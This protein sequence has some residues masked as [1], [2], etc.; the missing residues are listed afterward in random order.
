MIE[1]NLLYPSF[2][3]SALL[4]VKCVWCVLH[5]ARKFSGLVRRSFARPWMWWISVVLFWQ[6]FTWHIGYCS[7]NCSLISRYSRFCL[8]RFSVIFFTGTTTLVVF[9][10]RSKRL[11]SKPHVAHSPVSLFSIGRQ[12]HWIHKFWPNWLICPVLIWCGSWFFWQTFK[13][14]NSNTVWVLVLWHPFQ[15]IFK[16]WILI[17]S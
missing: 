3:A 14:L 7:K 15:Y 2:K 17:D 6:S 8:A 5:I 13:L 4:V 10:L 12:S 1:R 16:T 11:F 9:S